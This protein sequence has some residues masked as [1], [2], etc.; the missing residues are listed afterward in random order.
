MKKSSLRS[1]MPQKPQ[2]PK[3]YTQVMVDLE[4]LGRDYDAVFVSIGACEFDPKTGEIGRTFYQNVDWQ[5]SLDEGRTL[6]AGTLEWWMSQEKEALGAILAPGIPLVEAL[7]NF[8]EWL[9]V[10]EDLGIWANGPNFDIGKLE[11]AY[12]IKN[13]PWPYWSPRCVRTIS[14]LAEGLV[15]KHDM[16]FEGTQHNALDDAIYQATYV[17]KMYQALIKCN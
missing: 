12:G 17:S 5:S 6:D 1:L 10:S 11:T 3:Q 4:T 15:G 13:I 16:P 9:P 14:Q 8:A 2:Q 7:L